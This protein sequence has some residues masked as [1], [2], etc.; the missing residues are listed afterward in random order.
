MT[1]HATVIEQAS[2]DLGDWFVAAHR[3]D[4]P[5]SF[6]LRETEVVPIAS[7]FKVLRST[8][9]LFTD[10]VARALPNMKF[11]AAQV[12]GRPVKQLVQMPFRFDLVK[13]E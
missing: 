9:D 5:G 7:T 12:G 2:R 13:D 4:G 6:G 10:A 8:N 1:D 3:L 11:Y